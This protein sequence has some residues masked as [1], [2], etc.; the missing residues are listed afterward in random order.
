M[1]VV[2]WEAEDGRWNRRLVESQFMLKQVMVR[3]SMKTRTD[4]KVERPR[5]K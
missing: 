3:L 4:E 1:N 5:L 2:W